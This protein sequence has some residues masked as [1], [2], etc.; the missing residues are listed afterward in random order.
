MYVTTTFV[1]FYSN[2]FGFEKII[3]IPFCHMRCITKEKTALFIP[4]A[5]AIITSKKEYIFRSFWDR[6][7]AFKTLKQCQQ[8]ANIA[9]HSAHS[10]PPA[11]GP[12]PSREGSLDLASS[13]E[14]E[15]HE[16]AQTRRQS[17]YRRTSSGRGSDKDAEN[18]GPRSSG[19]RRRLLW[20][21]KGD[22]KTSSSSITVGVEHEHHG[23]SVSGPSSNETSYGTL[24]RQSS[25]VSATAVDTPSNAATAVASDLRPPSPDHGAEE[26]TVDGGGN[27]GD[28]EGV[29]GL[30]GDGGSGGRGGGAGLTL[31]EENGESEVDVLGV[32]GSPVQAVSL[33]TTTGGGKVSSKARDFNAALLALG[34]GWLVNCGEGEHRPPERSPK[35]GATVRISTEVPCKLEDFFR[36]FVSNDAE[37]GLPAFHESQGDSNVVA[38]PWKVA[39]GALG[40]TREIRFVHPVSAPIG[41]D[42]TRA[43]KLQRCRLFDEHGLILET[44][45][46]LEDILMSDYFQIDDRCV[47]QPGED[48][49]VVRVDVEV[50]IKFF[51]STMFRK[52]IET[53]SLSET[54]RVWESFI[55]MTKDAIRQRKPVLRS[56]RNNPSGDEEES[57]EDDRIRATRE[58]LRERRK[59]RNRPHHHHHH[60]PR[61]HS[62]DQ[63][64]LTSRPRSKSA[65]STIPPRAPVPE[66]PGDSR[67]TR[68]RSGVGASAT[69]GR[70]RRHSSAAEM[71]VGGVERKRG[72]SVGKAAGGGD[73]MVNGSGSVLVTTITPIPSL[74][75]WLFS[76]A[77]VPWLLL[78]IVFLVEALEYSRFSSETAGFLE[79]AEAA[80]AVLEGKGD[81]GAGGIGTAAGPKAAL[82]EELAR[83]LV[84]IYSRHRF[85]WPFSRF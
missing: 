51:K 58:R 44:S 52:T 50:E 53:K 35:K 34:E 68:G 78:A 5:I 65:A 38:T 49:S 3:K 79:A 60:H 10:A 84:R 30:D 33:G 16:Q 13:R 37:K 9:A 55:D 21:G 40:M 70:K 26:Q 28:G 74:K 4:N 20:S 45:T 6:E 83:G 82:K 71:G 29:A 56:L 23:L 24:V 73:V 66:A 22:Q 25:G 69:T 27:E 61:A 64:A 43:V 62:H 31:S 77:A 39:G 67:T 81:R 1:C 57:D 36:L 41:P 48:D 46:H 75:R 47:V 12:S 76:V 19:A 59:H 54:R 7:D 2:L 63:E 72:S 17:H 8:D 11:E 85:V 14:N 80:L 32:E 15:N 42:S 18:G